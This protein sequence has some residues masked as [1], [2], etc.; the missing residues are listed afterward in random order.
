MRIKVLLIF[1]LA[2]FCSAGPATAGSR[3][4]VLS[5]PHSF[6]V[7]RIAHGAMLHKPCCITIGIS[8]GAPR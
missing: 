8:S 3:F 4:V 5:A 2:G 1:V 6:S 7:P